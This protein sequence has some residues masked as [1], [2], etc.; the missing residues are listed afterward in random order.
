[1][2]LDEV[3]SMDPIPDLVLREPARDQGL[4]PQGR[5]RSP[6]VCEQLCQEN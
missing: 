6:I 3:P 2:R 4:V 1:M 5:G